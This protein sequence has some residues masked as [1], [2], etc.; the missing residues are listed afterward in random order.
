MFKKDAKRQAASLMYYKVENV[1]S[2]PKNDLA[3]KVAKNNGINWLLGDVCAGLFDGPALAAIGHEPELT[4]GDC[5]KESKKA[6][7]R[8]KATTVNQ[9]ST[10]ATPEEV[11]D[12]TVFLAEHDSSL[13][14][15][16][17]D[18]PNRDE[19]HVPPAFDPE[20]DRW[21]FSTEN[22]DLANR[23]RLSKKPSMRQLKVIAFVPSITP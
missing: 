16:T 9:V 20:D 4:L 19:S 6:R 1:A 11:S 3:K 21:S 14:V 12:H 10:H 7:K 8:K 15:E 18:F 23:L 17:N 5:K 22:S 2:P 13:P